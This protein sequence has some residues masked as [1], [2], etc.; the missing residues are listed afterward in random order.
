M[1]SPLVNIQEASLKRKIIEQG[2]DTRKKFRRGIDQ[3]EFILQDDNALDHDSALGSTSPSE[4]DDPLR[5]F[6]EC[7]QRRA[8]SEAR[9]RWH[10]A[11]TVEGC[12]Q[13][14]N[15]PCRLEAHMRSHNNERPFACD[16]DGCNKTFPRKDHLNRHMKSAHTEVERNYIC[17]WE[18]CGKTFTSS[19]RL[20][21]HKDV[22]ETKFYCTEYPPCKEIFRKAKTLE[23]HIK[24]KHLQTAPFVCDFVDEQSGQRC[25]NGYQTE[26]ALRRHQHKKHG[27]EGQESMFFCMMCPAPGSE[28]ETVETETGTVQIATEPLPF[29]KYED[30]VTHNREFHPPIC[31]DCGFMCADQQTLKHHFQTAHKALEDQ[32]QYPCPREGCTRVFNRNSNLNAHIRT[33][34]E[35][36]KRFF[37]DP[38]FFTESKHEDLKNWDGA[39]ACG[40]PYSAKSSL[41]QHIRTHHLGL[42]NRK[43][44]RKNAKTKHQP[45]VQK[46]PEPSALRLLTGFGYD[47][48]R[49]VPCLVPGCS[50]RF[51]M[52]RDLK[53][54]LRSA[55]HNLSDA[56]VEEMIRERDALTGGEFWIGGLD[57]EP[58]FE[59]TDPSVPQTPNPFQDIDAF[60]HAAFD[61]QYDAIDPALDTI[62][63]LKDLVFDED[64]ALDEDMGLSVPAFDVHEGI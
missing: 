59:S 22:H 53:R 3:D 24:T 42:E 62:G 64:A 28:F 25:S 61:D 55:E 45:R 19:S 13:R 41:E 56:E 5:D 15:R 32:A 34:H 17:D 51:F 54:H 27:A 47:G 1:T 26:Q 12:S 50:F 48:G 39:N 6:T 2:G 46:K 36:Q 52:D 57:Q 7:G 49:D 33:V 4:A 18:G 60:T 58:L 44:L 31:T 29:P 21:R 43:T 63:G 14:F 11:C 23:A 40:V 37:C 16:M 35:Q 30:L 8:D 9:R 20:Q 38:S 10:Y